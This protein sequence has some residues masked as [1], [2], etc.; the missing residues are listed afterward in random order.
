MTLILQK[1]FSI[2]ILSSVSALLIFASTFIAPS[3]D[4]TTISQPISSKIH[5]CHWSINVSNPFS[6]W[7]NETSFIQDTLPLLI[8]P[9]MPFLPPPTLHL[10]KRPEQPTL[11]FSPTNM[12]I[13]AQQSNTLEEWLTLETSPNLLSSWQENPNS[14]TPHNPNIISL[15]IIDMDPDVHFTQ[16][17]NTP[18]PL[19]QKLWPPV[20]YWIH[21]Q[22]QNSIGNPIKINS[23]AASEIDDTI[24]QVALPETLSLINFKLK[25]NKPASPY[26]SHY[27][28]A[29]YYP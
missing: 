17:I 6:H 23:S 13:N 18:A 1:R 15:K 9:T 28:K 14:P 16:S 11:T 12:I 3:L 24:D 22:G 26:V 29:E 5:L 7:I 2:W 10:L 25:N 19:A 27:L 8:P 20:S 4:E 21:T